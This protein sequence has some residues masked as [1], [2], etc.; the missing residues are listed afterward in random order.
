M[1]EKKSLITCPEC[2]SNHVTVDTIHKPVKRVK[3][4]CHDC[5]FEMRATNGELLF[6]R[7]QEKYG[8]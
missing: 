4:T 3:I 8:G 1:N 2:G 5:D 7:L 6:E